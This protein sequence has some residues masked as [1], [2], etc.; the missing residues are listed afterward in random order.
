M[1]DAFLKP[2]AEAR[3]FRIEHGWSTIA[4]KLQRI[5][6]AQ[7]MG[8]GGFVSSLPLTSD[9][10]S[11]EAN[12]HALR[13]AVKI[14]QNKGMLN[15]FYDECGW[16]SGR[17]GTL[18]LKDHPELD[19]QGLMTLNLKLDGGRHTVTLP[20]GLLMV[21]VAYGEGRPLDLAAK[22]HG[23]VL[24]FVLPPGAWR[25]IVITQNTLYHGTQVEGSAH[26]NGTHYVDVLNPATTKRFINITHDAVAS[27][28][29]RD[30]G[31][32]FVSLF[33]DEPNTMAMFFTRQEYG[34]LPWSSVMLKVF[35]RRRGYDLTPKLPALVDDVIPESAKLRCDF[36]RTVSELFSQNYFG[37]LTKWAKAHHT[38]SGGHALFEENVI[39]HAPLYGDLWACL[40]ALTVPGIDVLS[41]DPKAPRLAPLEAM[42]VHVPYDAARF[43]SSIA[44]ING[45]RL[46]MCEISDYVQKM[47]GD[48]V[49]SGEHLRGAYN[50]LL[51]GGITAFNTYSLYDKHDPKMI[52]EL[53]EYTARINAVLTDGHR[54]AD[55]AVLYPIES[56]WAHF[57][58]SKQW[59][60]D[61]SPDCARIGRVQCDVTRSLF[62]GMRDY[63][64][65]HSSTLARAKFN[66]GELCIG[67]S[68]YRAIV[69]P[70]VDT[71][72]RGAWVSLLKYWKSGGRILFV[73]TK[74]TNTTERFPDPGVVRGVE[75]M[76]N[77][78]S[79]RIQFLTAD[80]ALQTSKVVDRWLSPQLT[81]SN[82]IN[83]RMT[84][85]LNSGVDIY[86]VI[87]ES[88]QVWD[89][90]IQITGHDAEIWDPL[91]ASRKKVGNARSVKASLQPWAGMILHMTSA[92][93]SRVL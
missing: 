50:R 6:V 69:L 81:V 76:F 2:P 39:H 41:C 22:A 40:S 35:R 26:P 68:R 32:T 12:F 73:G 25:I 53:L 18:V 89:G 28:L 72:P 56:V 45:A 78:H 17:A 47:N 34:V 19:A 23:G 8:F 9:Y 29:G 66:Q 88:D 24:E 74:P 55:V 20:P 15:W 67:N 37:Q 1:W 42:D 14:I 79:G 43:A 84:H 83:L 70:A 82:N 51:W 57:T 49:L 58:P 63:D 61:V 4:A 16:P 11:S 80:D 36:Y 27:H 5:D 48:V 65:I 93:R 31:K 52:K 46:V 71:I 30:M 92:Q 86:F 3:V 60:S 38:L 10:A 77:D 90:N 64:Y 85:R 91:T 44:Q 75:A 87:N 59:A 54:V 21:A 13:N 7:E 62:E 33:T